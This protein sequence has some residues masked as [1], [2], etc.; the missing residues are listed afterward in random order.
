[1]RLRSVLGAGVLLVAVIVA[2]VLLRAHPAPAGPNEALPA[3]TTTPPPVVDA[4][5]TK[6]TAAFL[7]TGQLPTAVRLIAAP[8][9]SPKF[10]F[11]RYVEQE[12][13]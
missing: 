8:G 4:R 11:E 6:L 5:A 3:P 13:G 12:P 9:D 10:Q 1:M 7:H 2:V